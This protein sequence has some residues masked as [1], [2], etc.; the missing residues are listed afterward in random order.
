MNG[1]PL[2]ADSADMKAMVAY[3]DWMKKETKP[4]D[5]VAG[6]G[7]GKVDMAIKPTL[8]NGKQ[9]YATQCAVCHG[10]DGEGLKQTDGS[11]IYPPLWGDDSFNIGAGTARTYTAAAFVKRNMPI[12]FH[13]NFPLGQ[14]GLSD[15]EAVD[16]AEYFTHQPRPDFPDKVKDWP[17]DKKPVDSRY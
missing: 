17:K 14:G 4:Q 10:K 5:K 9:V 8:E 7:V 15:Q 12:G 6:C 16:V 1:K 3:F 2:P 11:F 13:E